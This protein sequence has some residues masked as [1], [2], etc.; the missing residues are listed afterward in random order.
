MP[1]QQVKRKCLFSK[2]FSNAVNNSGVFVFTLFEKGDKP[3]RC[4]Q[5]IISGNSKTID[6]TGVVHNLAIEMKTKSESKSKIKGST[7]LDAKT[8]TKLGKETSTKTSIK[9]GSKPSTK[10]SFKLESKPNIKLESEPNTKLGSKTS[11]KTDFTP[12][13]MQPIFIVAASSVFESQYHNVDKEIVLV[14]S[15]V[16]NQD[17][18]GR[19][20]WYKQLYHFVFVEDLVAIVIP[21]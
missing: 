19:Q 8:N 4:N 5:G 18:Q 10:T 3:T 11:G 6:F 12:I 16:I 20:G 15:S 21:D 1:H 7:K 2:G 14:N 17:Y 13:A 9:L